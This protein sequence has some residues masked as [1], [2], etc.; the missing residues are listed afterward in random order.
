MKYS[1]VTFFLSNPRM[2]RF[3]D[4]TE[5]KTKAVRLYKANL[6][7]AQSI[8]PLLGILEVILRNR[9]N[10]ILSNHFVDNDWIINQISGFMSDPALRFTHKRT[11]RIRINNYLKK[12]IEKA[13]KRI[14]KSGATVTNGKVIAEQTMGFWTNLF[15]VH[16]YK[17]LSGKP[18]KIFNNLPPGY[19]RKEILNDLNTIRRLRNRINHNEP[20]CFDGTVVD[21]TPIENIYTSI[22]NILTWIDPKLENWISDIDTFQNKIINAKKI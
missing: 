5:S 20:I 9:L 18:I 13:Q 4:S 3:L 19:G 1:E 2:Q 6:R 14:R 16:H 10:E 12:E 15:E 17:L 8:H 11:G 22:V 21:F 7:I